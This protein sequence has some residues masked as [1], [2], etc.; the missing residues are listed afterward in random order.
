[1][2]K[3]T[4]SNYERLCFSAV[5]FAVYVAFHDVELAL[6]S[7]GCDEVRNTAC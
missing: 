3:G 1:M 6:S 7:C 2:L 4:F 5:W